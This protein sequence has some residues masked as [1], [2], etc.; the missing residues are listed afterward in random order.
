MC[1]ISG[2]ALG[3]VLGQGKEKF[4]HPIYYARKT[5]KDAQRNYTIT[6]QE[7]LAVVYAFKK[8][9]A[10]L[11]GTKVVKDRK[12]CEN[13]VAE[14]LSRPESSHEK[15][16]E[17]DFDYTFPYDLVM[18]LS[19]SITPWYTD[20][21]NY[22]VSGVLPDEL[23]HYQKK[24]FLSDVKKY[25]WDEP[26][27]FS[28]C[29]DGVIR[30]CVMNAKMRAILKAYHS[31]PFGGHHSRIRMAAKVLQS[32]YYWSTLHR[33][34]YELVKT[35]P[36]FQMKGGVSRRHKMPL[37][38]NLEVELFDP[39]IISQCGWKPLL[40]Q[41]MKVFGA[42]LHKYGVKHKVATPYHP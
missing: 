10:Y 7:L 29:T 9:W 26:F 32:G 27:L 24:W 14:H 22:I 23:N 42:L 33:D 36:Q 4:F 20:Y 18:S 8:F 28:E 21:N 16:G 34:A 13:Q 39:S 15:L 35:C 25:F 19:R 40:Y 1:D 38:P 6:E 2:V 17:I 31:S 41:T 11:L 30:R 37:K 3:A 12:R 5:L